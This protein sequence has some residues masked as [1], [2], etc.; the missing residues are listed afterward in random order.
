MLCL[1]KMFQAGNIREIVQ[2]CMAQQRLADLDFL[3]DAETLG[4]FLDFFV[5]NQR[6]GSGLLPRKILP[7]VRRS[8][9]IFFCYCIHFSS[10][11]RFRIS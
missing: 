10:P 5:K 6:N 4:K 8:L 1:M 11:G 7:E 3:A 9:C 2:H